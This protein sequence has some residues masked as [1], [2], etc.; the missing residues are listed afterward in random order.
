MS[1]RLRNSFTTLLGIVLAL[2]PPALWVA[3]TERALLIVSLI[4][5]ISAGLL[6]AL[7]EDEERGAETS[8]ESGRQVLSDDSIADIHRI[9]PLTY[10]HS[11]SRNARFDDA[12]DRVRNRTSMSAEVR[13]FSSRRVR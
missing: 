4:G 6:I 3:W 2:V 1:S 8:T 10:H 13:G 9:F 11:L 7:T 5:I 12:M